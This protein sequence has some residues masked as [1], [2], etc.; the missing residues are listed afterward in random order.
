M[1]NEYQ[2]LLTNDNHHMNNH[3]AT[4]NPDLYQLPNPRNRINFKT[5]LKNAFTS[6]SLNVLLIFIPFGIISALFNMSDTTIFLC[7]FIGIIPLAKLLGYSTEELSLRTSETVGG[8]LNSTFGN[9][10]ELIIGVMALKNG[11]IDVVQSS[12]VGSLLSNLL[13]VLG[14]CFFCGGIKYK[15]QTFN[16]TSSN[17]SASLLVM[18]IFMVVLPVAFNHEDMDKEDDHSRVLQF[19]RYTS[20]I[21]L[22]MYSLYLLFQLKTHARYFKSNNNTNQIFIRSNSMEYE[23]LSQQRRNEEEG[24]Q[25]AEP[26]NPEEATLSLSFAITLLFVVT[27]VISICAEF[28]VD[29]IEGISQNW[30]LSPSFVGLILLPIVGNAAEHVTAITVALKNKMDLAIGV[31][32][33]SSMQV[34]LM[35]IPFLVITGWVIG[36]DLSLVFNL[37]ET[38]IIFVS[39][40]I[41][42]QLINDGKSN[43][44]EGAMLLSAYS[45]IAIAYWLI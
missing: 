12:M 3:H 31:A 37:F 24:R 45:I 30:N 39:V 43:W 38:V 8:L 42:N 7:N 27:V 18:T 11:L 22:I 44:L 9:A 17:T 6:S 5:S 41:V 2:P 26:E 33:G 13:L 23:S 1:P 32:L 15:Y 35:V 20:V 19:S 25:E 28:L 21:M 40:L 14:M 16:S 36:V 4:D 34:S 10:V 29:S